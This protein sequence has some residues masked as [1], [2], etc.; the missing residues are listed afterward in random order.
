M[1]FAAMVITYH[2]D[3]TLAIRGA[4]PIAWYC[5]TAMRESERVSER[6]GS[7]SGYVQLCCEA[8]AIKLGDMSVGSHLFPSLA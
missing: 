5:C 4:P 3:V 1:R 2:M 8:R 6:D 7:V